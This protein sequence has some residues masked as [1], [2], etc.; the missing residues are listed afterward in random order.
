MSRPARAALGWARSLPTIATVTHLVEQHYAMPVTQVA[1]VRSFT[2]DVYRIDDGDRSYA[3]KIY[4]VGRWTTDEI[5]WE[6]QLARHLTTS[7]LDVAADVA[8]RDGDSAGVL[9]APEGDRPFAMAEWVPGEKPQPPW[10][11]DLYRIVGAALARFHVVAD[12][13][14]S[15]HPRRSVRVGHELGEVVEVLRHEPAQR[16]LVQRA[17]A[18]AEQHVLG[19]ADRGLRWGVRHGDPS[20]DNLHI[21]DTGIHLYDFDLAGPGWQVEDLTGALSMPFADVFMSGYTAVRPLPPVEL[22]ALPWLRILAIIDNL[23]F[24]LVVK[25]AAVGTYSLGEG[26]V[27]SALESLARTADEVGLDR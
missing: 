1:L 27:A 12:E 22:E 20:L 18:E 21:S 17:A 4:G 11:A 2:N 25:P 15:S 9:E 24:H 6:Q 14:H 8:L 7:G 10:T 23:H 19:L 5:R 26:W 13:F 3:L 16:R